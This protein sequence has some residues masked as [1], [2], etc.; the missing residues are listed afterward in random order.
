M[1]DDIAGKNYAPIIDT[2]PRGEPQPVR[3]TLERSD[4]CRSVSDSVV[5]ARRLRWG[6]GKR[7]PHRRS[8]R[9]QSL[10]GT[11]VTELL[12]ATDR[13]PLAT[14]Q[15]LSTTA[16]CAGVRPVGLVAR[17]RGNKLNR[18]RGFDRSYRPIA[19]ELQMAGTATNGLGA[20]K[21]R[22]LAQ[23]GAEVT[24]KRLRAEIVAIER[25]FP[26]LGLPRRRRA[27]RKSVKQAT[28]RARRMSATARKAVSAR[29]K[30]YWAERRKAQA[31][32]K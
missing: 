15:R 29:M 5:E 2:A 17:D 11:A 16:A 18:M 25:A 10:N 8:H 3:K 31:K 7:D 6:S 12:K 1:C 24:L 4:A 14:I 19:K 23:A 28:N 22:E 30:R 27:V 20:Q 21:L 13:S 9:F 26:E 32:V